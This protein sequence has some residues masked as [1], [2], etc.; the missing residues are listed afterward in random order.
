MACAQYQA[1]GAQMYPETSQDICTAAAV[2]EGPHAV[3]IS[4]ICTAHLQDAVKGVEGQA[5]EGRQR[6][7]LVVLVVRV[8]QVPAAGPTLHLSHCNP[9][10]PLRQSLELG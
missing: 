3:A 9:L 8:V 6:V 10:V 1:T 5:S 7:L 4:T 2:R